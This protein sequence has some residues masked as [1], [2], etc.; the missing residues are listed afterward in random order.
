MKKTLRVLTLVSVL[1]GACA[2][3]TNIIPEHSVGEDS[4]YIING[5]TDIA[6]SQ[7]DSVAVEMKIQYQRGKQERIS[8]NVD[9][10]PK[11]VV[12]D[13]LPSAGT[14]GFETVLRLKS[15]VAE[16]GNYPI[17]VKGTSESGSEK[18]YKF[19][20]SIKNDFVCDTFLATKLNKFITYDLL[21]GDS[22]SNYSRLTWGTFMPKR[23]W[24]WL[25][26]LG[27]YNSYP[28][29]TSNLPSAYDYTN[30]IMYE[31]DCNKKTINIPEKMITVPV[32]SNTA[33]TDEQFTVSGNGI[34]DF[35]E[36]NVTIEYTVKD[37]LA[38]THN[39]KK[40]A[41]FKL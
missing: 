35:D 14:P 27:N 4:T 3:K 20:L 11:R 16:P 33:T 8:L 34:I 7:L 37:Y 2:Q 15:N 40:V 18:S 31:F 36:S 25:L 23:Y 22:V 30:V 19:Y 5:V 39:Y 38:E 9:G 10:L 6:M 29:L 12:A 1:F 24:I 41:K 26:Y 21:T 28:V 13:F 17:I 32:Y